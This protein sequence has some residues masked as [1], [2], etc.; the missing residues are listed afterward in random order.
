MRAAMARQ[1]DAVSSVGSSRSGAPSA[2]SASPAASSDSPASEAVAPRA[3]APLPQPR[4][5]QANRQLVASHGSAAAAAAQSEVARATPLR[6]VM[7]KAGD[8]KRDSAAPLF[9]SPLPS[10]AKAGKRR[11]VDGMWMVAGG[12]ALVTG[13]AAAAL[14][15]Q[16]VRLEPLS[17]ASCT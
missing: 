4:A 3:T 11:G 14:L 2:A 17:G 8:A 6:E 10:A 15:R 16:K 7:G 5:A 9:G 13:A 1:A 12:S